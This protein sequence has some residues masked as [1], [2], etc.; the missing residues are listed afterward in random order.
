MLYSF[1]LFVNKKKTHILF[2]FINT[3]SGYENIF[4]DAIKALTKQA[5][6]E[7]STERFDLYKQQQ[8]NLI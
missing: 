1:F 4:S 8:I 3:I 2:G 5:S 7:L 6:F